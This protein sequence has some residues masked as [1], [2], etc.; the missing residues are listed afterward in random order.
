MSAVTDHASSSAIVKSESSRVRN[1]P[2]ARL[3]GSESAASMLARNAEYVPTRYA[4]SP[5]AG[6]FVIGC[7]VSGPMPS[8]QPQ[9]VGSGVLQPPFISHHPYAERKCRDQADSDR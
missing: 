4:I 3:A 9:S 8:Q 2:N 7:G 1:G 6:R 5:R